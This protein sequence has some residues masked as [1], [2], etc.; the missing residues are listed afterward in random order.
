VEEPEQQAQEEVVDPD[1]VGDD[2]VETQHVF[3]D[4]LN[5]AYTG[6]PVASWYL[7]AWFFT[8]LLI[9]Y[10]YGGGMPIMYVLGVLFFTTSY[11]NYKWLFFFWHPTSHGFNED[12][13]IY[14][15]GLMKWAV[16]FHMCMSL[17]MYSNIR[18]LTPNDYTPA[19]H[20]RPKGEDPVRFFKRRFHRQ[21][22]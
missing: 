8:N 5:R 17:F 22:P 9:Y 2:D 14:S 12:I 21:Q 10:L 6:L 3:Q 20:Y 15:V 1:A 16:L 19:E 13:A 18:V 4:E 11:L 7:Y